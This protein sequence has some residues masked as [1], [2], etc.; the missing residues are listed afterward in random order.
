MY[1]Y[2]ILTLVLALS[3]CT[4]STPSPTGSGSVSLTPVAPK[5]MIAS[6]TYGSGKHTVT[7]FADFQCPACIAFA[8]AVGPI[9]E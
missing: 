5:V 2:L 8:K 4:L 6:P 3:S 7:I 1:K 9:L